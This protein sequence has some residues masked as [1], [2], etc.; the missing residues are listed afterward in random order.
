MGLYCQPDEDGLELG[1]A[2]GKPSSGNKQA[3]R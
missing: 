2:V 3:L 1:L